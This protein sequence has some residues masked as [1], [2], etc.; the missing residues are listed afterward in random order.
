MD[1]LR[2]NRAIAGCGLPVAIRTP[3]RL[4]ETSA[5]SCEGPGGPASR[6]ASAR[7]KLVSASDRCFA[8]RWAMPRLFRVLA[9]RVSAG[10]NLSASCRALSKAVCAAGKSWSTAARCALIYSSF[11]AAS[12]SCAPAVPMAASAGT[13][14]RIRLRKELQEKRGIE[15][16]ALFSHFC[17]S[18]SRARRLYWR[19][20]RVPWSAASRRALRE[21]RQSPGS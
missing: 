15:T 14:S 20:P 17:G 10:P 16:N 1:K 21:H 4:N 6:M 9:T 3:A 19:R 7:R 5:M 11:Q 18:P 8:S 2:D 13:T 12:T